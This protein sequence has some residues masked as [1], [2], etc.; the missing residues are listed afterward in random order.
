MSRRVDVGDVVY[1]VGRLD[2]SWTGEGA[3]LDPVFEI[4][5]RDVQ[6]LTEELA[7]PDCALTLAELEAALAAVRSALDPERRSRS[8][9]S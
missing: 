7:E 8:A 1:E 2:V 4:T 5:A 3:C 6:A 9:A